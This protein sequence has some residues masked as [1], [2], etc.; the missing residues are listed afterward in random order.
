MIIVCRA[1]NLSAAEPVL[2]IPVF[3]DIRG[4]NDTE[5]GVITGLEYTTYMEGGPARIVTGFQNTGNHYFSGMIGNV[6]V[7]DNKGSIL[8]QETTAPFEPELIP[9]QEV[10]FEVS[11][12]NG[13]LD[14]AYK[15][16]ARVERPDGSLLAE[17][18][19][20]LQD[21]A[22]TPRPTSSPGFGICAALLAIVIGILW[23]SSAEKR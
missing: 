8:A 16:T 13:I 5:T 12:A 14:T 6:T 7:T 17:Q 3:L 22:V 9:G 21:A 11:I 18:E 10:R 19:E 2:T 4:G 15:M 1:S 23:S 20:L